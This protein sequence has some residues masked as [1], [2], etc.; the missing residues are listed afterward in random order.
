MP[1]ESVP[2]AVLGGQLLP[3]YLLCWECK[4][5]ILSLVLQALGTGQERSVARGPHLVKSVC[6]GV[7][8]KPPIPDPMLPFPHIG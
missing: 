1:K 4:A 2:T 8:L 3:V 7:L 5:G 6:G